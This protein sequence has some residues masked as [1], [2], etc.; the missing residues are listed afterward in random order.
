VTDSRAETA[1][2]RWPALGAQVE[3]GQVPDESTEATACAVGCQDPG[4]QAA[5][6]IPALNRFGA[7]FSFTPVH[8]RR[9][10]QWA[11]GYR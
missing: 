1:G 11:S 10:K 6:G 4:C 3:K 5:G 7:N 8:L 2:A 9:N